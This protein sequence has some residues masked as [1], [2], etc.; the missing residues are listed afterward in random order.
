[1][2]LLQDSHVIL[3]DSKFVRNFKVRENDGRFT[4]FLFLH[5]N[6]IL[7]FHLNRKVNR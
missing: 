7:Y 5:N 2:K 1:M 4:D 6:I 3:W